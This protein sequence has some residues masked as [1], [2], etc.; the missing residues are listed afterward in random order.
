MQNSI[1]QFFGRGSQSTQAQTRESFQRF[2]KKFSEDQQRYINHLQKTLLGDIFVL[3]IQKRT[4]ADR[5]KLIYQ[6]NHLVHNL[7]ATKARS[8]FIL[9]E[10]LNLM[11]YKYLPT[12]YLELYEDN[13]T[14][15]YP[16]EYELYKEF[17]EKEIVRHEHERWLA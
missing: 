10:N 9:S 4:M 3:R 2:I 12:D 15:S 16:A 6:L 13:E 11:I 8:S 14:Q 17:K 7:K 1:A 5:I